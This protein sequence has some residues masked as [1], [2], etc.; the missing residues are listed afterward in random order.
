MRS[1][2][3]VSGDSRLP[4]KLHDDGLLTV[5]RDSHAERVVGAVEVSPGVW[6]PGGNESAP[7]IDTEA[8]RA[9]Q[10]WLRIRIH[11]TW[12]QV[13]WIVWASIVT[14]KAFGVL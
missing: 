3:Y 6:A 13:A 7:V 10:P 14:A 9:T 12:A 8:S 4:A 11:M 2:V 5:I 1:V